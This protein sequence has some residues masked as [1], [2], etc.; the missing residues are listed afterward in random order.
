MGRKN[1][2]LSRL[3]CLLVT[4]VASAVLAET[5]PVTM[6]FS[7][8]GNEEDATVTIVFA[9]TAKWPNDPNFIRVI[10][11]VIPARSR[12]FE[13]RNA[14]AAELHRQGYTVQ[15]E[16]DNG[17]TL[18]Y[19]DSM[20]RVEFYNNE[21]AEHDVV[22]ASAPAEG[23]VCFENPVFDPFDYRG[24]PAIFTAGIVTDVGTL[25][26]SISAA[27][28]NFQT[29]GQAICQAL[30]QRLA[31][32]AQQ[33][34]VQINYA[35]DRLEVNFDPA[36]CVN[37]GG[38]NWGTTSQSGGCG[39]NL[40]LEYPELALTVD[41][42]VAGGSATFAASGAAPQ[43]TISFYYG[44]QTGDTYIP[45]LN[46]TLDLLNPVF[47]GTARADNSGRA[48]IVRT[49]PRNARGL[50]VHFQAAAF[51]KLSPVVTERVR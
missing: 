33:F 26:A 44:L 11:V 10:D 3:A 51:E 36:S 4:V 30:Y 21:T 48:S 46:V 7:D 23:A 12:A 38:V 9:D 47:M 2:I 32:R 34:G 29:S 6:K 17:L 18:P 35:G 50:T 1:A 42:L 20:M 16:G 28:L 14:I 15:S 45:N 39:G 49:V 5:K 31:P 24:Q 37:I 19:L 40:T 41:N 25:S 13:K 8:A 43:E 27:E 22:T